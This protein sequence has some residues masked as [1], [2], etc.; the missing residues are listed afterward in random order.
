MPGC[1]ICS[2]S[3]G[4]PKLFGAGTL[5]VA[6]AC[7]GFDNCAG[8]QIRDWRI[9]NVL[10]AKDFNTGANLTT[11]LVVRGEATVVTGSRTDAAHPAAA[12]D[13]MAGFYGAKVCIDPVAGAGAVRVISQ[14]GTDYSNASNHC[15]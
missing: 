8:T 9:I 13:L 6:W 10:I 14:S 2:L 15:Y 11:P 12:N 1:R 7:N 3:L 5:A 4:D